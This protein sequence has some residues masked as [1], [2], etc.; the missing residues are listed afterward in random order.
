DYGDPVNWHLNPLTGRSWK[1]DVH[2]TAALRDAR[3]IGDVKLTWEIGR[4]PHA[5][6]MGRAA[7]FFPDRAGVLEEA[8]S[9]QLASFEWECPFGYGVHW[10]S[11]QEVAIRAVALIFAYHA[12]GCPGR[13]KEFATRAL[14]RTALYVEYH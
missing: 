10:Y 3:Q 8:L 9:R 5:Y 4:F 1:R 2:W 11:G 14:C 7:A 6:L 13:L 12:F